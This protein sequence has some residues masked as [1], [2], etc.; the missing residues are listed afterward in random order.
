MFCFLLFQTWQVLFPALYSVAVGLSRHSYAI[1]ILNLLVMADC[2]SSYLPLGRQTCLHSWVGA[3]EHSTLHWTVSAQRVRGVNLAPEIPLYRITTLH[4]GLIYT[5]GWEAE[6]HMSRVFTPP[7]NLYVT[8]MCGSWVANS[9]PESTLPVRS[10]LLIPASDG[11]QDWFPITWPFWQLSVS[12]D[13]PIF[14]KSGVHNFEM[15]RWV[16]KV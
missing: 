3:A 8:H 2:S 5:C 12:H 15:P 10:Q 6:I 14:P 7:L 9:Y 4:P 1:L 13:K 11:L 16:G